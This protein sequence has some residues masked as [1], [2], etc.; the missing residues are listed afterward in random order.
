MKANLKDHAPNGFTTPT[1]LP[2]TSEEAQLWQDTNRSWWEN[3]SMRYDWRAKIDAPEFSREFYL[4]IDR[5]FFSDARTY[6]PWKVLP[7][8][9][10]IDFELLRSQDVLEIGVGNGS[11]AQLLAAHARSFTGVDLTAYAVESTT[12]RLGLQ[13]ITA[14]IL[15]MDAEQLEFPDGSFDFVWSWGVIHHSSNTRK[16]L[17]QIHRVLRPGGTATVMVYYRSW[18]NYYVTCGLLHGLIQGELF[19]GKTIHD[20]MQ[21]WTDGALARFYTTNEWKELVGDLFHV[22]QVRVY[23]SKAEALPLPRGRFKDMALRVIPDSFTRVLLNRLR[24]GSYLVTT[25]ERK[26]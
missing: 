16:V 19:R 4:E 22:R 21:R 11:H 26:S 2:L 15:R 9:A 10:L 20:I 7:F 18:W 6:L 3:N 23:G 25:L 24:M 5:R 17:Q 12:K 8:D 13:G 1:A 14:R